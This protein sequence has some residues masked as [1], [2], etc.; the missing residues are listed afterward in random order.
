M[1]SG[2]ENEIWVPIFRR[3]EVSNLGRVASNVYKTRR[4]LK[5]G[6]NN[7]GYHAVQLRVN[8]RYVQM[9]VHKLVALV[10]VN[11][12]DPERITVNHN[13]GIKADNRAVNLSWMTYSE[14][15]THG[16]DHGLIYSGSKHYAAKLDDTQVRV[17]K[18]LKGEMRHEDIANY[19]GVN[20]ATVSMILSGRTWKRITV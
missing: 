17:I 20:R 18:S 3:Y 15:S 10:F 19:F 1:T 7:R 4:I 13:N 8:L 14:N 2:L 6:V 11:N 9:T 16:V 5:H 12:L